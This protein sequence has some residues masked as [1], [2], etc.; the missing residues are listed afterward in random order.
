ME[1]DIP[2]L[3]ARREKTVMADFNRF[4]LTRLQ[5]HT[6]ERYEMVA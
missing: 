2:L 6:F 5:V 1:T 4:M 3:P